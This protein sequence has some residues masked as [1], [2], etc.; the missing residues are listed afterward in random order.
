MSNRR[1]L[2]SAAILN[3]KE[4]KWAGANYGWQSPASF[5]K[6]KQQNKLPKPQPVD[7]LGEVLNSYLGH[8]GRDTVNRVRNLRAEAALRGNERSRVNPK[9]ISNDNGTVTRRI[10][11]G[12]LTTEGY[13]YLA[14]DPE[15]PNARDHGVNFHRETGDYETQYRGRTDSRPEVNK[16]RQANLKYQLGDFI[17]DMNDRDVLQVHAYDG[18]GKGKSRAGLY[19]RAT[20][21]AL[22]QDPNGIPGELSMSRGSNGTFVTNEGVDVKFNPK[23]LKK[24]LTKL[25]AGQ[26]IKGVV[27]HPV[28]KAAVNIDEFIGALAGTRPSEAIG[29]AHRQ[30]NTRSIEERL[31]KGER[32]INPN[33]SF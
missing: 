32:F 4:V 6:L 10:S 9:N 26:L 21:G 25:A 18:D 5:T 22:R 27:Q 13:N 20:K 23:D 2:G 16:V 14:D 11:S 30:M 7:K 29:E 3:G 28:A 33:L 24:P 15:F 31:K 1:Q 19:Q 8:L 12:G 17:D